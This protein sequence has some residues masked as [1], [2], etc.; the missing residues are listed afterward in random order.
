M[1][2]DQVL[3]TLGTPSTVSTVGNKQLVLYQ[4]AVPPHASSSWASRWWISG[5]RPFISTKSLRVERVALYGMQDGKVFDFISRT[6]PSGGEETSFLGQIFKAHD[7]LQSVRLIDRP[8]EIIQWPGPSRPFLFGL[9]VP[10][11]KP[12]GFRRGSRIALSDRPS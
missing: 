4:P 10:T 6:T 11:K 8:P 1:S 7:K 5:S 3:Q 12:R 2:A 9:L